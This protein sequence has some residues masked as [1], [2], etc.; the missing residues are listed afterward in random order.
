[1]RRWHANGA[2]HVIEHD[3]QP[4]VS[5]KKS[6]VAN[7]AAAEEER[8]ADGGE[9]ASLLDVTPHTFRHSAVTWAMQSGVDSYDAGGYFGLSAGIIQRTYGHHH[10]IIL[11]RV[12]EALTRPARDAR[13]FGTDWVP[14][15]HEQTVINVNER[16]RAWSVNY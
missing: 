8:I 15:D 1:M 13:R 5:I 4:V 3:R 10:R 12:G 6:F 14:P 16:Q 11:N 2:R 9:G 7:V